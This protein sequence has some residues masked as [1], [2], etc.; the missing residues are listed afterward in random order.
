MMLGRTSKLNT[1]ENEQSET[2][3]SRRTEEYRDSA[4]GAD[5]EREGNDRHEELRGTGVGRTDD[6]R[7]G[8]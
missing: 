4:D 5:A 7:R 3:E 8:G 6:E 2:G 1:Y